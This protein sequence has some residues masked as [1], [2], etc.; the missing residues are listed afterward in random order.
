MRE[1]RR[2]RNERL[3]RELRYAL[4][5]PTIDDFLRSEFR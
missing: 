5:Y 4:R 2:L 1:S 3:G